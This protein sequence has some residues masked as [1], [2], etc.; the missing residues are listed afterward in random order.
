MSLI[1]V[2]MEDC[3][4]LDKRTTSNGMGGY[5]QTYTDGASFQAA[6]VKD[7]TMQARMAEKNGVTELYTV[8]VYKGLTL[9]YHD[10]FRRESDGQVFRVTSNIHDS[11]PPSTATAPMQ[12]AQVSAERWV[13]T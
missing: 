12:I 4:L 7:S 5:T 6:I 10:I 9:D 2:M 13:L 11:T 1:D 3:V 8:T